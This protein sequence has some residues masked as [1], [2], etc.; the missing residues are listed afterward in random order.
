LGDLVI[1]NCDVRRDGLPNFTLPG[2]D[3]EGYLSYQSTG[4]RVS[5][6]MYQCQEHE[7]SRTEKDSI[8]G[9]ETTIYWYTYSRTWSSSRIR[10]ESF[11][12]RGSRDFL[13]TCGSDNPPWPESAPRSGTQFAS[14]AKAGDFTLNAEYVSWVPLG[15]TLSANQTP[16]GWRKN[17]D[18]QY[19]TDKWEVNEKGIGQ[20]R[21][22][23]QGTDWSRPMVT[24]L[25][26]NRRGTPTRWT[27]SDSWLCSGSTL[28][29]LR[30]GKLSKEALFQQIKAESDMLTYGLRLVGF[31]LAWF[32][33]SRIFEPC[34]VAA[35][36]VP[37]I[38]KYIGNM[39]SCVACC[40]SCPPAC[41]FSL[42]VIA[43]VWVVMRPLVA[44]PLLAVSIIVLVIGGY[45]YKKARDERQ[46][47]AA[48]D[49]SPP[50]QSGND[51]D[52]EAN[53]PNDMATGP[54]SPAAEPDGAC[55]VDGAVSGVEA[56][57]S[58]SA[59]GA[60]GGA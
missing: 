16:P 51:A 17:S 53:A 1:F 14:S 10:S 29:D 11:E 58:V 28:A 37:F 13:Q 44:F 47:A 43:I 57:G 36:C 52:L 18:G 50:P 27:A 56:P 12:E 45:F 5:A 34:E 41:A 59:H 25:G 6:E 48:E 3:F 4:L 46:K 33:I 35:D 60:A 15:A 49:E 26:E 40:I 42:V 19:E 31:L 21:F 54:I 30:G 8:G 24:V 7:H 20:L 55:S 2:T 39:V 9:G 32:A 38:G 22:S 23:V